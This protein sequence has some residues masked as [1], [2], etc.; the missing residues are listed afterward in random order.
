MDDISERAIE[1]RKN[2]ESS[3]AFH[4]FMR[5]SEELEDWIA[6]QT[7][8]A[9]SEDYGQDYEHIQVNVYPNVIHM[10][11]YILIEIYRDTNIFRCI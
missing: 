10:Y 2:L 4:E 9:Q 6:E 7:Q 5:E 1:R 3:K 11:K 8:T